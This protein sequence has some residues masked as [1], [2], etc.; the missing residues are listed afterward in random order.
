MSNVTSLFRG[1]T[2]IVYGARCTWWDS[3][4]KVM[5]MAGLPRCPHC[6]G[7]LYEME[8]IAQWN[9]GSQ[10]YGANFPGYVQLIEWCRGKCFPDLDAAVEAYHAET[11]IKVIWR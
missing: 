9:A 7:V 3:I 4:D 10:R 5:V 11:G 2:R 6:M 8:N 1:D